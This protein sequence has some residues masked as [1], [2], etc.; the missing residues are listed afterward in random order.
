MAGQDT[1]LTREGYEKLRKK[2]ERLMKVRRRELA[3]DLRR[4][5][6]HGDLSENAE[7]DAAKHAQALNE[8]R[9]AELQRNLARAQI[10]DDRKIATDKVLLGATV[11]LQDIELGKEIQYTLVSELEADVSQGKISIK[12][13]IAQ[14]LLGHKE[15]DIVEIKVPSNI[16]KYKISE[17]SR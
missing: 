11:K 4:A 6:E 10:I 14:G 3:E 7:Y 13:P 9:I 16:M 12:S 8:E 2:L 17:I 1:Y 15:N 5:R